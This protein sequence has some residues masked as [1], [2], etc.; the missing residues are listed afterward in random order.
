MKSWHKRSAGYRGSLF[1]GDQCGPGSHAEAGRLSGYQQGQEKR[2][3]AEQTIATRAK[4]DR[5]WHSQGPLKNEREGTWEREEE[6]EVG[7]GQVQYLGPESHACGL[8][9]RQQEATE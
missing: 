2:N 7:K 8:L 4:R 6:E 1:R 5:M 3:P 9:Q